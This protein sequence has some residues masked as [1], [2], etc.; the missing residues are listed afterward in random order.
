M[1]VVSFQTWMMCGLP[2]MNLASLH[3]EGRYHKSLSTI[4][5]SPNTEYVGQRFS[6]R[7]RVVFGPEKPTNPADTSVSFEN[8]RPSLL[9]K[10]QQVARAQTESEAQGN[11]PAR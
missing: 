11:Y 3:I 5:Q 6:K 4:P 2:H 7:L 9:I 10:P 1:R 8:G